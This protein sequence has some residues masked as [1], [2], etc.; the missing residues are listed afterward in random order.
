MGFVTQDDVL[1]P[2]L[3]V[4]ETLMYAALLRLPKSLN[5]QQ[6]IQRADEIIVEL[7]LERCRDTIIGGPFLRGVSGGERKRVCI[8]HEI[9]IDPSLLFLDEPTSGLDS[10]IALRI[11]QLIQSIAQGGRTVVASVHQPS[12]R[13]FYMFSKVILLSEGE[14]VYY[15]KAAE[16]MDYFSSIGLSPAMA[17]NPA[18]FLLDLAN[19]NLDVIS[20]PAALQSRQATDSVNLNGKADGKPSQKE[21]RQYLVEKFKSQ[22]AMLDNKKLLQFVPFNEELKEAILEKREWSTSWWQQFNVLLV[23]GLSERRHEYLSWLRVLQVTAISVI[24]GMLWWQSKIHNENEILDQVGLIFF[25]SIFWA[26]FPL[27]TAIFTFPQER[28]ILAKERASDMYRLSAYFLSRTLG[29]V[30]MDMLLVL[31]FII[32]V[33]FMTHLH[34]SAGAF[35]LTTL[36]IILDAV[37][38]QGLGLFIGAVMMDVKK[39]TTMA[40]IIMLTFMLTG[41]FYVQH[42]PVFIRWLKYL[43]FNYHCFKLLLKVQYSPDQRYNCSNPDGCSISTSPAI[44]NV[45]LG[46]GGSEALALLLMV[47]GYRALGYVALRRMKTGI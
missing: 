15:G 14:T 12:S 3:T 40:S 30:P 7:G 34:L 25:M 47:V 36:T 16:A 37:T 33:Y 35:F 17:M 27:F 8:G 22:A 18:D 6:K 29:D 21:V 5:K 39:A 1:F 26:F 44:D 46:G 28:A 4:R 31:I 38:S 45:Q 19:G 20:T 42:I 10:T 13:L 2:H 24:I 23:R 9:L 41:G 11:V 43:S 32:I